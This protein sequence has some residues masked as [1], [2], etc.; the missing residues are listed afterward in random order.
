MQAHL[1][2]AR[3]VSKC[4]LL[5]GQQIR[6]SPCL[7][8][9]DPPI[10]W[11]QRHAWHSYWLWHNEIVLSKLS[12]PTTWKVIQNVSTEDPGNVICPSLDCARRKAHSRTP[13]MIG[14]LM[15]NELQFLFI[16]AMGSPERSRCTS[17]RSFAFLYS[18]VE[19][20]NLS[21][22]S[23][24]LRSVRGENFLGCLHVAHTQDTRQSVKFKLNTV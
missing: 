4:R 16:T 5:S 2:G 17:H 19:C 22:H 7:S 3:N 10:V 13:I 18:T 21:F 8:R 9:G 11:R 6:A 14:I 24:K 23:C 15:W 1:S 20:R 12:I